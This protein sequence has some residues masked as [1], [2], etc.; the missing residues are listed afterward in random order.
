MRI[1]QAEDTDDLQRN[2]AAENF[3]Y[4][5]KPASARRPGNGVI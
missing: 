1:E 2:T 5:L 3:R 4:D